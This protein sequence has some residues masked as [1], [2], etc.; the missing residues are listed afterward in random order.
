M[1]ISLLHDWLEYVD[2][3]NQGVVRRTLCVSCYSYFLALKI[4]AALAVKG[5]GNFS[6][7]TRWDWLFWIISYRASATWT[8]RLNDQWLGPGILKAEGNLQFLTLSNP[9]KIFYRI[10]PLDARKIGAI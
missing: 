7:A 9:T 5:T 6:F 10:N 8:N 4:F 1:Y 2:F 3:K